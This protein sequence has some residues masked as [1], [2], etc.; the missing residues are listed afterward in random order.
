MTLPC[1]Y[2]THAFI[3]AN[4]SAARVSEGKCMECVNMYLV[5]THTHTL[6]CHTETCFVRPG[7]LLCCAVSY[8]MCVVVLLRM[9][10]SRGEENSRKGRFSV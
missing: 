8:I 5:T 1:S 9:K 7:V 6:D 4:P 10:A 2:V 3:T